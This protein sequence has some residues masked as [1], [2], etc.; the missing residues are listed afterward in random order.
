MSIFTQ[1]KV[2]TKQNKELGLMKKN[3]SAVILAISVLFSLAGCKTTAVISEKPQVYTSFYA[4]YDFTKQIAQD[5]ADVYILCSTG[6]EPHD[7]EP[8]AKDI[9]KLSDADILIYNGMGMEHWTDSVLNTLKNTDLLCVNTSDYAECITEENDP[10]IW[11]N[12][13][14]AY[15]QFEAIADALSQKDPDNTQFYEERLAEVKDKLDILNK[16]YNNTISEF[17]SRDIVVSHKAY[18][19]LCNAYSLNQIPI[20]G[21][22]NSDD[23]T[24]MQ[25]AEI[26]K[27]VLDN[28]IK[29]IFKE[30]LSSSSVVETIANDTSCGVLVLDPFEGNADGKDYF[31]VMYENLEALKTALK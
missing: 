21:I 18:A 17:S 9:S 26:E 15:K 20:N 16:D 1:V 7:Y 23:P 3:I 10:H 14:N 25:M 4:M 30:P 6:Q 12:P 11:L 19:N 31:T 5:K 27:Y 24:P 28:N 13:D 2:G 22:S 29:Y 8:T